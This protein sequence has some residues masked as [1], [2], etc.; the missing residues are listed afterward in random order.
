VYRVAGVLNVIGGWFMTAITAFTTAAIL[1]F[2][3]YKFGEIALGVLLLLAIVLIVR[4]YLKG[5]KKA[6]EFKEEIIFKKAESTSLTGVIEESSNNVS[7][8]MK[9]GSKLL[10]YTIS[11]LGKQNLSGL[12][13]AQKQA[14]KLSDDMD[15]LNSHVFVYMKNID[16]TQ[17][18]ASRFYLLVQDFLQDI[19]Q[20]LTLISNK[21]YKHVKNGHKGLKYNQIKDLT[22]VERRLTALFDKVKIQ[23][24][25]GTLENLPSIIDEKEAFLNYISAEIEKQIKR[26]KDSDSSP[27]N[28]SLYFTIL[29]ECKDLVDSITELLEHYYRENDKVKKANLL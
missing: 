4:N 9:R 5:K 2:I 8:V 20:S 1:A 23:F 18:G 21:S 27:R 15:D 19:V 3:I 25:K 10:N 29:L 26:A 12:R 24:D 14:N 13:K 11:N 7:A 17:E 22:E 16:E 6:A 28:T